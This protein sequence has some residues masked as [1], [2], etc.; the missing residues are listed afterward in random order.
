[1][2]KLVLFHTKVILS[3]Y[4]TVSLLI[5]WGNVLLEGTL[6]IDVKPSNFE[7]FDGVIHLKSEYALNV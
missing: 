2:W 7:I 5:P 6:Q 3:S 4:Y 1:M